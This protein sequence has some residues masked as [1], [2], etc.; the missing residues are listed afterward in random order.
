LPQ[1]RPYLAGA[2]LRH[3]WGNLTSHS[4]KKVDSGDLVT[5]AD[6]AAEAEWA[7]MERHLPASHSILAEESGFQRETNRLHFSG[8]L[9]PWMAPPTTPTNI[10]FAAVSI[11]LLVDRVPTLGVIYNPIHQ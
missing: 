1:K 10:P 7:V 2:V 9:T 11:G 4:A 3:Y 8:P 5:E 6:K